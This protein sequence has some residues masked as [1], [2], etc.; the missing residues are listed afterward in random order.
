M[1]IL[2]LR[3][4]TQRKGTLMINLL[5]QRSGRWLSFTMMGG[6]YARFPSMLRRLFHRLHLPEKIDYIGQRS[7]T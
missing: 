7:T 1:T 2:I 5:S 4:Q 6:G 3:V